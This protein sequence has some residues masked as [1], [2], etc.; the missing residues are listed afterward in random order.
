[1]S[2]EIEGILK[3]S[4]KIKKSKHKFW[5]VFTSLFFCVFMF[6]IILEWLLRKHLFE[7]VP[8][9]MANNTNDIFGLI[10]MATIYA[11]AFIQKQQKLHLEIIE[12]IQAIEEKLS[13]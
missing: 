8:Y 6:K 4:S 3:T 2:S 12:R 1:M 13:K 9:D 10:A 5:M 11:F 7:N